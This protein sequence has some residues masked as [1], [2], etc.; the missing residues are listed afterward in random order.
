MDDEYYK[1]KYLK[2]KQKY[3]DLKL[4]GGSSPTKIGTD[5]I[6]AKISNIHKELCIIFA[7]DT[8]GYAYNI[9][10]EGEQEDINSFRKKLSL[11][12]KDKSLQI[13]STCAQNIY[14]EMEK[15][16]TYEFLIRIKDTIRGIK[17]STNEYC[18]I[19]IPKGDT[20][21]NV[22]KLRQIIME[23][24]TIEEFFK[25][26]EILVKSEQSQDNVNEF[27]NNVTSL[28][29]TNPNFSKLFR[30]IILI[31]SNKEHF[32]DAYIKSKFFTTYFNKFKQNN[33]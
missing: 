10:K 28:M 14:N 26:S 11:L 1:K 18:S 33:S 16:N 15:C 19:I 20:N 4:N 24:F 30:H 6:E 17:D 21:T 29:N 32:I 22:F 12:I 2:Y 3:L 31:P 13:I 9:L 7:N 27:I 25:L 8:K 23:A 5:D